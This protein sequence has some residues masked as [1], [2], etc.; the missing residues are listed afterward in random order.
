LHGAFPGKLRL[1]RWALVPALAIGLGLLAIPSSGRFRTTSDLRADAMERYPASW[2]MCRTWAVVMLEV[3]GPAQSLAATDRC[4]E[5]F[6]PANFEKN[7]A[8]A[9]Y[10]S[11]G[12]LR[13]DTAKPA[14]LH[15]Q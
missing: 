7:R 5:R 4:M 9:L 14:S 2:Q 3:G 6:G 13:L 1:L 11:P 8:V 10:V 12:L 15:R